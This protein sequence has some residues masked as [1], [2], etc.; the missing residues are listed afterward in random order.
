MKLK[1]FLQLMA[2]KVQPLKKT[3]KQNVTLGQQYGLGPE[4]QDKVLFQALR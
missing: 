4:H 1:Y 3:N 2:K